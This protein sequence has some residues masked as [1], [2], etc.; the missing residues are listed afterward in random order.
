MTWLIFGVSFNQPPYH[1]HHHC[2]QPMPN[3]WESLTQCLPLPSPEGC[4]P[5]P[6]S[7]TPP[8]ALP[9]FKRCGWALFVRARKEWGEEG[10]ATSAKGKEISGRPRKWEAQVVHHGKRATAFVLVRFL[11]LL[12]PSPLIDALQPNPN[13]YQIPI[14]VWYDIA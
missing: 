4:G 6:E 8:G 2:E 5:V 13:D 9:S 11:P 3:H 12:F 7:S 10:G 14:T 1:D